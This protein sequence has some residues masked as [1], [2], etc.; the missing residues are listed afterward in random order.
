MRVG[1][2]GLH[3]KVE[4]I[5]QVKLLITQLDVLVLTLLGNSTTVNGGNDG[6]NGVLQVLNHDGLAL[7]DSHLDGL[8]HLG[9]VKTGDLQ[10]GVLLTL[11]QPGDTLKLR[12]NDEGVALRVGEDGTVLSGDAI[13]RQLLGL[14]GGGLGIIGQNQERVVVG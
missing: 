2:L 1:Q 3:V 6:V 8:D 13:G 7:L 9:V 11:L 5:G 14:P 10:V 12:I 4:L